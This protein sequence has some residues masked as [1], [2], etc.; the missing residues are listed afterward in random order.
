MSKKEIQLW[1]V[2]L[3][4]RVRKDEVE[5]KKVKEEA[6]RMVRNANMMIEDFE[7]KIK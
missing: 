3:R 7:V 4:F 1:D 2:E 6:E 5:R